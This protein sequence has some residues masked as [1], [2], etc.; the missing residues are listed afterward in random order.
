MLHFKSKNAKWSFEIIKDHE[1]ESV[2]VYFKKRGNKQI[3]RMAFVWSKSSIN[4]YEML[5]D[6]TEKELLPVWDIEKGGVRTIS[7]NSVEK[8]VA[9]RIE[10]RWDAYLAAEED[11]LKYEIEKEQ[12][13][14]LG[15]PVHM[16]N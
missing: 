8:I 1:L 16:Y 10:Y 6:P 4:T 12:E 7:M 9:G 11:I 15:F 14:D 2:V 5:Y 13:Q 3:R